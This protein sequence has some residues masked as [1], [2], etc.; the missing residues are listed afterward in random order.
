MDK[1][2]VQ[3]EFMKWYVPQLKQYDLGGAQVW[4]RVEPPLKPGVK[5]LPITCKLCAKPEEAEYYEIHRQKIGHSFH[6]KVHTYCK[7]HATNMDRAYEQ[8]PRTYAE[9]KE[10][11]QEFVDA[12]HLLLTEREIELRQEIAE[13]RAKIEALQGK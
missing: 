7:F 12:G 10:G 8:L 3:R 4:S 2:E 9:V 13:L 11:Q 1:E 6:E 5:L